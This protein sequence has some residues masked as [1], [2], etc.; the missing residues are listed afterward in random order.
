MTAEL[1]KGTS[2]E[3]I[4]D[5]TSGIVSTVICDPPWGTGDKEH[6][7]GRRQNRNVR[8]DEQFITNDK[9]L[10]ELRKTSLTMARVLKSDGVAIVFC[11]Q[12]RREA[13]DIMA[14]VGLYPF[15][16]GVQW[17]K[18]R[19]GLSH[20]IRY[21]QEQILICTKMPFREPDDWTSDEA[22][23][24]IGDFIFKWRKPLLSPLRYTPVNVQGMAVHPNEKPV[25]LF[26]HL[27]RWSLEDKD[28]L[29]RVG[30]LVLDPF[31][32]VLPSAI[33]AVQLGMDWIGAE[34]DGRWWPEGD[35]RLETLCGRFGRYAGHAQGTLGV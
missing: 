28:G 27:I 33:A 11:G 34:C 19:P 9:N 6:Q 23:S 35:A 17:D 21:A 8:T 25:P 15:D 29:L 18:G 22:Q 12:H 24:A 10:E 30:Q 4:S 2:P 3:V 16:G 31:C 26:K 13:E 1:R 5:L 20:K 32:G 14:A 7:Y